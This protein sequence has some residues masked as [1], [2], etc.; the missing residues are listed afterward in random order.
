MN[1]SKAR[2]YDKVD[3]TDLTL[4]DIGCRPVHELTHIMLKALLTVTLVEE[5]H[6]EQVRPLLA[7]LKRF[8]NIR[9]VAQMENLFA[10]KFLFLVITGVVVFVFNFTFEYTHLAEMKCHVG[11]KDCTNHLFPDSFVI[12]HLQI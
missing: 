1:K 11:G 10:D 5:F 12:F 3:E 2:Q 6:K 8:G 4:S 9:N 7:Q